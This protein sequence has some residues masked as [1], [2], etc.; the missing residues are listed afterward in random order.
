[1]DTFAVLFPGQGA[2]EVGM[3]RNIAEASPAARATLDLAAEE[4]GLPLDR[5]CFEGPIETLSRSD[6]AQPAILAVSIAALQAMEEDL[7]EPLHP[8]GAAGLSLGE[9]TALVAAGGIGLREALRAVRHRGLYM[10]EACE[11]NPGTMYSIIGLDDETVE[12][13]CT[14]VRQ[15]G[16]HVWPANYNSPGQVVISGEHTAAAAAAKRC[17]EAGARRAIQLKVA[18]AFHCPL[19]QPAADRLSPLIR[20]IEL[21]RP[22]VTVVHNVTGAPAQSTEEIRQLLV[23]QVTEPVRWVACQRRLIDLGIRRFY[24]VGPGR[25][26]TGLLRRT[27]RHCACTPVN[28]IDDVRAFKE[29][30][31]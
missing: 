2:Q 25:V 7:G 31:R 24:E 21:R 9:Y 22:K 11:A 27:D 8:A 3:G 10:Q 1:M 30:G 5:I 4:S 14:R 23:R 18:G 20:D 6:V 12:R 17:E 26:L 19:M 13:T 29:P 15:D 16:G 28:G